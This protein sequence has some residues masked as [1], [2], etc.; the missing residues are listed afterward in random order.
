[1]HKLKLQVSYTTVQNKEEADKTFKSYEAEFSELGQVIREESFDMTDKSVES[2]SYSY[3]E[4]GF[5]IEE[6]KNP[7]IGQAIH[8]KYKYDVF[9]R[10]VKKTRELDDKVIAETNSDLEDLTEIELTTGPS[11]LIISKIKRVFDEDGKLIELIEYH[12]DDQ[13]LYT[14]KFSYDLDGNLT[15]AEYFDEQD[16]LMELHIRDFD[17]EGRVVRFE[18]QNNEGHILQQELYL[19]A[20]LG[21]LEE[22]KKLT[23]SIK[24]SYNEFGLEEKIQE[25][26]ENGKL[27][28]TREFSYNELGLI[29]SETIFDANSGS[30]TT[31]RNDYEFYAAEKVKA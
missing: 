22:L 3:D 26:D 8:Y 2:H 11:G 31:V 13:P 7:G 16:E 19:Y 5:L 17:E 6:R 25:L 18:K 15:M 9:G 21:M 27:K 4:E 29:E 30:A 12:E 24:Y 1:M 28:R 20:E 23:E 10:M 14:Q